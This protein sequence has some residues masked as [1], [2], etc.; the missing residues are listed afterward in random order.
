MIYLLGRDCPLSFLGF[1]NYSRSKSPYELNREKHIADEA[2]KKRHSLKS[3][4]IPNLNRE[5][6]R[7]SRNVNISQCLIF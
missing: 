1:K 7:M 2:L 5:G 4:T 6:R 3:P